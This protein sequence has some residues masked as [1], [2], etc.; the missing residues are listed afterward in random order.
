MYFSRIT[1]NAREANPEQLV[2]LVKSKL[3]TIHQA[4]WKLFPTNPQAE[5]DFIFR[6]ETGNGWPFFYM[7]SRRKPESLIDL[8]D[9]ETKTYRP[10]LKGSEKLSFA[11][12]VNPVVTKKTDTGRRVRHD[13]VMNAKK[14][15]PKPFAA[16]TEISVGE[17]EYATGVEWLRN[18]S[19]DLGFNFDPSEIRVFGYRQHRITNPK[20]QN[21]I[22]FSTLDFSGLLTVTDADR[23]C[24]TLFDGVGRAKAFGCGLMLVK[25][26]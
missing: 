10:K 8:I 12:R 2:A 19:N 4:L 18:R 1:I 23:F 3:Y 14:R 11:L 5:R 9:V 22:R 25:K 26:V 24:Q 15:Y 7:V 17:L 13:V 21:E 16:N 20:K 6:E